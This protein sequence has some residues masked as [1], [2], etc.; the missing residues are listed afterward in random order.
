MQNEIKC[1]VKQAD[2]LLKING[3]EILSKTRNSFGGDVAILIDKSLK[4]EKIQPYENRN[5]EIV[6][7]KIVIPLSNGSQKGL[8]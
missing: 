7:A 1:N 6:G 4:F 8:T 3:Y 5:E 2:L